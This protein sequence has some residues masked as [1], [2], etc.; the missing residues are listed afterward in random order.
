M[1]KLAVIKAG[2]VREERVCLELVFLWVV[3]G[4][5]LNAQASNNIGRNGGIHLTSLQQALL[6]DLHNSV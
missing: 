4:L 2:A 3:E 1:L 5:G 6:Y